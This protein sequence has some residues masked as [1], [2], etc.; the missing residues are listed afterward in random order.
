MMESL[1]PGSMM[2]GG[3]SYGWMMGAAGYR[4]MMGGPGNAPAWMS[5]S[6]LPGFM[7]G[8]A[9]DPGQVMGALFANAPGPRVTPADATRLGSQVP[10]GAAVS[11]A[12]HQV[13]FTGTFTVASS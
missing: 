2:G 1:Y 6:A 7:M 4:W 13:T 12:P 8:T 5:G 10:A 3:T 11:Q 9:R